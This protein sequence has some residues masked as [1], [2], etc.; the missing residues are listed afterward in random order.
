MRKQVEEFIREARQSIWDIR[1]PRLERRDLVTALREVG[2]HA[3]AG[4]SIGFALNVSGTARSCSQ[5]VER[6]LLRIGQEAVTNAVRHARATHVQIELHY[7]EESV[8][9]RVIDDGRGFD[10]RA[11]VKDDPQHYGLASMRERA[12]EVGG[13][14]EVTSEARRGTQISAV[15]PIGGRA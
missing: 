5:K 7:N 14:L 15:V 9:L 6:Q 4:H 1:S 8:S 2:G 11:V 12:E 13:Q 10:H 3:T